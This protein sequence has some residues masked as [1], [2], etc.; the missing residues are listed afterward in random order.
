MP[1]EV[2]YLVN[3]APERFGPSDTLA[4]NDISEGDDGRGGEHQSPIQNE[5][6]F[7]QGR[8]TDGTAKSAKSLRLRR[9]SCTFG[10]LFLR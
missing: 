10:V 5:L 6:F 8:R 9:A 7:A 2:A 1:F 4:K 3:V